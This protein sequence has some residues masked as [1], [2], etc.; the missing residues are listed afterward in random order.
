MKAQLLF[1]GMMLL[2]NQGFSCRCDDVTAKE[3][4]EKADVVF[5]GTVTNIKYVDTKG[6]KVFGEL[7]IIVTTLNY[8]INKQGFLLRPLAKQLG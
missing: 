5:A 4:W 6:D 8:E 7:R 1:A 2:A 3:A